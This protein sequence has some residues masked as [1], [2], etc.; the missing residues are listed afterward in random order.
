MRSWRIAVEDAALDKTCTTAA[1]NGGHWNAVGVPCMYT[2]ITVEL[3]ALEKFVHLNG[4]ADKLVLVAVDVPDDPELGYEAGLDTLPSDW[5]D[6][7]ASPGAE[8]FGTRFLQANSHLWLRVPS[9]IIPESRN[10]II[11]PRHPAYGEVRLRIVRPFA[12]DPRMF[13]RQ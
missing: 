7:P 2:G 1:A 13:K 4:D 8:A 11:N 9:T 6:M 12:F 3:C 10:L 5:C